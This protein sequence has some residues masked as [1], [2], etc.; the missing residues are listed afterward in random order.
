MAAAHC[1]QLGA[2]D[3]RARSR[4]RVREIP[5][6]D[7]AAL[8]PRPSG[9]RRRSDA[10]RLGGAS[11]GCPIDQRKCWSSTTSRAVAVTEIAEILEIPLGTVKSRLHTARRALAAALPAER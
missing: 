6:G 2:D 10:E 11:T 9:R 4:R 8:A 5:A 3:L 1:G 7:V